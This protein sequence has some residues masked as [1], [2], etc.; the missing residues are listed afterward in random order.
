MSTSIGTNN[1][2][3]YEFNTAPQVQGVSCCNNDRSPGYDRRAR[4]DRHGTCYARHGFVYDRHGIAQ[5]SYKPLWFKLLFP[6]QLTFSYI[7]ASTWTRFLSLA[8]KAHV[9]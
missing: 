8:L 4:Y 5:R 9:T 1:R 7:I 6:V 3:I 2:T